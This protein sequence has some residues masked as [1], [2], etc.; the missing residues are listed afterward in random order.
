MFKNNGELLT[1]PFVIK[2][3]AGVD[4][5]I[6]GLAYPNTP[7]TTAHKNVAELHFEQDTAA[8]VHKWL[9]V[10]RSRGAQVVVVLSHLGLGADRTLAQSVEG[11]D[12][13]VGGHSHNRMHNALSV[14]QTLIVQAGA[15]GSDVGR[16]NLIIRDGKVVAHERE[17]VVL[18]TANVPSDKR[19]T[20]LMQSIEAPYR[21]ALDARIGVAQTPI[22]PR[23]HWPGRNRASAISNRRPTRSLPTSSGKQQEATS[24]FCRASVMGSRSNPAR[25]PRRICVIS[26]RT[27][28]RSSP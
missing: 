10:M 4:V 12:V 28:R 16:L 9:P 23:R 1:E 11:I 3:V 25:L 13:I 24:H 20:D 19:I 18:D 2:K 15:H 26:C 22:V 7:L 27:I 21:S 17:L 5:G 14:G 6:L 8:V